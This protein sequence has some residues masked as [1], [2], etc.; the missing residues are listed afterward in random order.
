MDL[1]INNKYQGQSNQYCSQQNYYYSDESNL[2][3]DDYGI[4]KEEDLYKNNNQQQVYLNKSINLGNY[5]IQ[6][7]HFFLPNIFQ[8]ENEKCQ[9]QLQ[10]TELRGQNS[11]NSNYNSQLT[12]NQITNSYRNEEQSLSCFSQI[13]TSN[14]SQNNYENILSINNANIDN[15]SNQNSSQLSQTILNEAQK[16]FEQQNSNSGSQLNNSSQTQDKQISQKQLKQVDLVAVPLLKNL[17]Q[18]ELFLIYGEILIELDNIFEMNILE[19]NSG[20][21]FFKQVESVKIRQDNSYVEIIFDTFAEPLRDFRFLIDRIR[22]IPDQ[23]AYDLSKII[24]QYQ[25]LVEKQLAEDE[26]NKSKYTQ[27]LIHQRNLYCQQKSEELISMLDENANVFYYQCKINTKTFEPINFKQGYSRKLAWVFGCSPEVLQML[28]MRYGQLDFTK[29]A[30]KIE[31]TMQK[32]LSNFS[33]MFKERFMRENNYQQKE[34]SINNLVSQNIMEFEM[35]TIDD[36]FIPLTSIISR[37]S[38]SQEF[39]ELHGI[40]GLMPECLLIADIKIDIRYMHMLIKH[41]CEQLPTVDH[42]IKSFVNSHKICENEEYYE[43]SKQFLEKYYPKDDDQGKMMIKP[44][45]KKNNINSFNNQNK[46]SEETLNQIYQILT[47][48]M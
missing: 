40:K 44:K 46:V 10:Q 31:M 17:R 32:V 25:N 22:T 4:E 18:R 13:S 6:N 9:I 36:L 5:Q 3:H 43:Q 34:K 16:N 8:N 47:N 33:D 12:N 23:K 21:N 29:C 45:F 30:S 1:E 39:D 48:R 28:Y 41:R 19:R 2:N 7:N 15:L 35:Q 14:L 37:I 42:Y 27:E 38:L 20:Y 26:V 24:E 11:S